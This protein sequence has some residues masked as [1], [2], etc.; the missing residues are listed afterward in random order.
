MPHHPPPP[1][2]G[3]LTAT[4]TVPAVLAA[5]ACAAALAGCGSSGATHKTASR[6]AVHDDALKFAACMRAHGVSDFPD[7]SPGGG[8][9]FSTGSGFNP[10][11]PATRAA[12][13]AC[14]KDLPGGGPGS[15]K[16]SAAQEKAMVQTSACMR[17]HGVSGFPDPT[18]TPPA[19]PSGYS[20]IEG[21]GGL[22]ILVPK[23]IVVNSPAFKSASLACNFR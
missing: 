11:A 5:L 22:Y 21:I 19:S 1:V 17:A 2:V 16:V 18:T 6:S 13:V 9:A 10:F 7:P 3:R 12:R 20:I 4:L 23:T 8:F 14:G 15:R